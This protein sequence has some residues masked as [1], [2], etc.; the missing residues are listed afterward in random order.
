MSKIGLHAVVTAT[1]GDGTHRV[2]LEDGRAAVI[3]RRRDM[4][5]D[6][7]AAE[8]A[9]LAALAAAGGL[10]VPAVYGLADD[11]IAIED[12]GTGRADAG[13]FERAGRGLAIQ[14]GNC[15]SRFGFDSDGWCGD[16]RQDNDWLDDGHC[17]FA[18]RRLLPQARRARERGSLS[19]T[20][21][22]RI[23]A[24]CARL[25]ELIPRQ[26]PV[27]LHGDLWTGNL[28]CCGN[29]EP[30][31]IDA[32]AVHYGWAEAELAMLTLFGSPPEPFFAAYRD[33]APL[34]SDWRER[35]PL[36]NLYHL[37][38]HLN[39]FGA[40]YLGAVRDVLERYD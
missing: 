37:L 3:K 22:H 7:F 13:Y 8:A 18:E 33:T 2:V 38:N 32:G 29:G 9:G 34:A 15:D 31:L 27:L 1:S 21:L 20:Q 14:H 28:H 19:A 30:A 35:A 6:F 10:R 25:P 4:P 17:H 5:P 12:L 23:E 11:A 39:L 26:P 24:L 36:Y 40:G 16:S